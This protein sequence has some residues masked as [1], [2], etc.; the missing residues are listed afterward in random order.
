MTDVTDKPTRQKIVPKKG[1][2]FVV[3]DKKATKKKDT[4]KPVETEDKDDAN[5]S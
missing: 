3:G 1:G 2:L 5:Q 4:V